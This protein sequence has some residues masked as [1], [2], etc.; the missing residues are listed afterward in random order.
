MEYKILFTRDRWPAFFRRVKCPMGRVS[1]RVKCP[2]MWSWTGSNS[3]ELPGGD[4]R[5]WNW[6]I[7]YWARGAWALGCTGTASPIVNHAGPLPVPIPLPRMWLLNVKEGKLSGGRSTRRGFQ[8][9]LLQS[10]KCCL[11]SLLLLLQTEFLACSQRLLVSSKIMHSWTT[12]KQAWCCSITTVDRLH[13][14]KPGVFI[15]SHYSDII[16][17]CVF[18]WRSLLKDVRSNTKN[19]QIWKRILIVSDNPIDTQHQNRDGIKIVANNSGETTPWRWGVS[20]WY[21]ANKDKRL[22]IKEN[23]FLDLF[24]MFFKEHNL[25]KKSSIIWKNEHNFRIIWPKNGQCF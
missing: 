7:H 11:V 18:S 2:T 9:G 10:R 12:C 25:K 17:S 23:V 20:M 16:I 24:A 15:S 19:K 1:I 3:R 6:L 14:N 21:I 13:E 5:A 4:D 8:I 22:L